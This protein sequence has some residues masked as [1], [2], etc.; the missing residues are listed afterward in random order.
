MTGEA[1]D[2]QKP[3]ARRLLAWYRKNKRDLPWRHTQDPY[4]IWISEIMLQQTQVDTVI[5]Y[6]ERFLKTFPSVKALAEAPLSSILKAWE[7]LGY[8]SRAKHLHE[9]AKI[10]VNDLGGS[11]PGNP[12]D[13]RK[14]PGIGSYTAGA[15]ASIAFGHAF[16]AVDG[17]VRRILCRIFAIE[18]SPKAP[19]VIQSL[20]QLAGELV[21]KKNPGEFNSAVMDL[22]A[23]LCRP[24]APRCQDCPLASL[25]RARTMGLENELPQVEKR[26]KIPHRQGVCAVIF[27]VSGRLL[28]VQRPGTGLLAS[29]WKLPGGFS[30][31]KKDLPGELIRKVKEE[32][33]IEIL[34]GEKLGEVDHAY[35]HFRLTLHAFEARLSKGSPRT[36]ITCKG[37]QAF[38]WAGAEDLENLAFSRVDRMILEKIL[39]LPCAISC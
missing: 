37:C 13:L 38:T 17:N 8:Y 7:N 12:E 36:P 29:L 23:T 28:V 14:L 4:A 3:L 10:I 1:E 9:T 34:A 16:P 31:C 21:P 27:D 2:F 22:G 11:F 25:C 35:T 30:T 33:G 24:K 39:D 20:E 6:Y 18:K 32:L 5:P 15:I 26:A 19:K